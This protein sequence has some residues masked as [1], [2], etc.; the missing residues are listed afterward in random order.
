MK[1]DFS[2]VKSHLQSQQGAA[3]GAVGEIA[4]LHVG[5]GFELLRNGDVVNF[6][7]PKCLRSG[8]VVDFNQPRC[9]RSGDVV[10][11][12]QPKCL[13]NCDFAN[14]YE[15]RMVIYLTNLIEYVD[16]SKNLPYT[17]TKIAI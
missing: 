7:Q 17:T 1:G 16:V 2:G 14:N 5:L 6:N 15:D 13:R 8:D 3:C 9:L 4:L 12:N 11:F 10:Y